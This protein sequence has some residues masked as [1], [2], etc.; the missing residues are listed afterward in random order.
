MMISGKEKMELAD[1]ARLTIKEEYNEDADVMYWNTPERISTVILSEGD[2]IILYPENAH[3]GAVQVE[4]TE[5]VV[6][7]VGKVK[8]H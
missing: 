8:A 2:Y 4:K 5:Q 7:I 1:V 6:K 3:R